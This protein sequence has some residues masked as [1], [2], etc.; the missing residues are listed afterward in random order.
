MQPVTRPAAP[1]TPPPAGLPLLPAGPTPV[2][3]LA[4]RQCLVPAPKPT[5]EE[6]P[7]GRERC[8]PDAG[9]FSGA[10]FRAGWGPN[11]V[12]AHAGGRPS[13]AAHIVVRQLAVGARVAGAGEPV[14]AQS[15]FQAR[16]R[17]A[18]EAALLLH[19][20]HSSP[21]PQ[22]VE[23]AEDGTQEGEEAAAAAAA[24][25]VPQWRLHCRRQEELRKLTL[26]YIE[27][28]TAAAAKVGRRDVAGKRPLPFG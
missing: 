16:Q 18:L 28:L 17:E 2:S 22:A 11:A 9:L 7:A 26:A 14:G 1:R 24:A 13:S 4:G 6:Q 19:M 20:Q 12:V 25:G 10:V 15:E 27:L 3:S 8:L 23:P 5:G 21:D